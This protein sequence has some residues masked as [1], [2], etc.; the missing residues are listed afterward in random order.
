MLLVA[1]ACDERKSFPRGGTAGA[2]K[3]AVA[4]TRSVSLARCSSATESWPLAQRSP[5][6]ESAGAISSSAARAI[7]RALVPKAAKAPATELMSAASAQV[8]R[9]AGAVGAAGAGRGARRR[10][11]NE[12]ITSGSKRLCP[13]GVRSQGSAPES[14][15]RLTLASLAHKSTAISEV[16][17]R[18]RALMRVPPVS[19]ACD[20]QCYHRCPGVATGCGPACPAGC[21]PGCRRRAISAATLEA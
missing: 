1:E 17:S 11:A 5:I 13:P 9:S 19:H 16:P 20:R 18:R 2:A 6:S 21:R 12:L 8:A 7:S 3:R 14:A 15:H 4:T 10:S